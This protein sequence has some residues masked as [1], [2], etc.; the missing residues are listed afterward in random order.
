MEGK[1]NCDCSK[2]TPNVAFRTELSKDLGSISSNHVVIFDEVDL[3]LGSAYDPWHG[4][5]NA[6]V[7]GTYLF[8]MALA[9]PASHSGALFM[10]KNSQTIEFVF[11]ENTSAGWTMGGAT[12]VAKLTVGDDVWVEGEGYI[13]GAYGHI[14]YHTGFS[15]VLIHDY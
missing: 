9:N 8:S 15:G 10:L 12:T 4:I 14:R 11:G 13:S 1:Q 6:P 5:F 7:N 3:N 2:N